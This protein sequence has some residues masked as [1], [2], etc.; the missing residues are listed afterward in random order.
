MTNQWMRFFSPTTHLHAVVALSWNVSSTLYICSSA[1]TRAIYV[2]TFTMSAREEFYVARLRVARLRAPET[3]CCIRLDKG[4][5]T[6][7]ENSLRRRKQKWNATELKR[8]YMDYKLWT[9][10]KIKKII[11]FFYYKNL[12]RISV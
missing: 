11:A 6:R 10:L 4:I 8:N 9:I 12:H 7:W 3:S 5:L 2:R 1:F